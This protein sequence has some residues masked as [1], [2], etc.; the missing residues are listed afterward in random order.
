M[1]DIFDAFEKGQNE[2]LNSLNDA[3]AWGPSERFTALQAQGTELS[4]LAELM[5][6]GLSKHFEKITADHKG[7]WQLGLADMG[8]AVED[9]SEG[10]RNGSLFDAWQ[11]YWKDAAQ[12]AVLTMDVLRQRG[13]IFL[14]HEEAGCPPVLIYD[15][16]VVMDGADLPRPCCYQLLRIKAPDDGEHREIKPWKRPYVIIDP[17]AGHGAGIGGFKPDS[18]VG[19]ALRDGHPVYFIAFK[20]MPEKGQTLADVTLAEAAFVRRIM[21]E[22]PDAPNPIITGNCQGGWA[23]LLLAATN[24]D[25]TG[26]VVLN[27]APVSTWA[28]RVGE[29]PMR[30]NGGI[31]GGTYNAMFY[32][33]LGH[34]VFDGADIVQ[35]FEMLNPARNYFGKYYDLYSKVDTEPH[36]FLEFERWWGGYFLLNEAEMKW[37]VEQLLL[38]T[39]C[40]RTK[41]SWSRAATSTSSRSARRSL[42]LPV[43]ATTSRRRSKP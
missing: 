16:D 24:P 36:R 12:R 19:V 37:I 8:K 35:N 13:D 38:A 22:H 32:S 10:Q 42:P 25:L 6:R 33:D 27:G 23:T 28:G 40:P 9:L 26:P 17:R 31:L 1:K 4:N 34:G 29:N 21:E 14:E 15:Y 2:F 7:R 39:S 11:A 18:Q 20:R 43:S 5:G 30:Y 41:P 3:T